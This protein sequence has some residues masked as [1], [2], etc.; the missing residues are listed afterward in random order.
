MTA[1][2]AR[3][4]KRTLHEHNGTLSQSKKT[5]KSRN[6]RKT[7]STRK[8]AKVKSLRP[9]RIA[10]RNAINGFSHVSEISTDGEEE[11]E[12][13]S[14]ESESSLRGTNIKSKKFVNNSHG[15]KGK[16]LADEQLP[17]VESNN[18][19][20]YPKETEHQLKVENRKR[21]VLKFS[22]R[23][24][25]KSLPPESDRIQSDYQDAVASSFPSG[26]PGPSSSGVSDFKPLKDSDV[27]EPLENE[28]PKCTQE[29]LEI[30]G[31]K[32]TKVPWGEVKLRT[33][34]QLQPGDLKL[35]HLDHRSEISPDIDCETRILDALVG[36]EN[37]CLDR[38]ASSEIG[39]NELSHFNKGWREKQKCE[40][41]TSND[42]NLM[43]SKDFCSKDVGKSS[44]SNLSLL[45]SHEQIGL[46]NNNPG[47]GCS[48]ELGEVQKSKPTILKIKTKK[49]LQGSSAVKIPQRDEDMT[50]ESPF[51]VGHNLEHHAQE[52]DRT[53]LSEGTSDASMYNENVQAEFP[54]IATDAT[55]RKRS[56]RLKA[57]S[58]EADV[59]NYNISDSHL[60]ISG[61]S[62]ERLSRKALEPFPT[63][64]VQTSKPN[65][66]SRSSKNYYECR[67]TVAERNSYVALKKS[68]WLLLSEQEEGYRYIP[69]L[70][71]VVVY[72]VQVFTFL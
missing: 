6:C 66:R 38:S 39:N 1:S 5:T 59:M 67:S 17:L 48:P 43:T 21:L 64:G 45:H 22:I 71:D 24:S 26:D 25:V 63:R 41:S 69:Q 62:A 2:G 37:G 51:P 65:I 3:A 56:L 30:S 9:Q 12:S 23:S 27:S 19:V 50:S 33:A 14:S 28:E 54:D 53:E 32:N 47:K 29:N 61:R 57:T 49:F 68:N 58:R 18:T 4:K 44:S 7:S 46:C 72:L 16:H 10:A 34:E 11:S 70:G 8:S 60:S 15:E 40:A 42:T 35:V 52:G 20:K 36:P 13:D 31:Y 55:R